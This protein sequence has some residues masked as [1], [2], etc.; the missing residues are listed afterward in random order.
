MKNVAIIGSGIIGVTAAIELNRLGYE[1]TVFDREPAGSSTAA[2]YGN[3]GWLCP[4][5]IIPVAT[6][7]LFRN[8]PS[9]VFGKSAPLSG[10]LGFALRNIGH[11]IRFLN[12]GRTSAKVGHKAAALAQ[13]LGSSTDLHRALA[14]EAQL[15]HLIRKDGLLYTYRTKA[16]L[17][18]DTKWWN[19]RRD[20]GVR[21]RFV[22]GRE[23]HEMEPAIDQKC[24]G[25]ILVIDGGHCIDP[26]AYVKGLASFAA[27]RGVKFRI[28]EIQRLGLLNDRVTHVLTSSGEV[29]ADNIVVCCGAFSRSFANQAGDHPSLMSERGYHVM[30]QNGPDLRRPVMFNDALMVA[31]PMAA[32]VRFAGQVEIADPSSPPDWRRAEALLRLARTYFPS[33]PASLEGEGVTKWMGNRPAMADELPVIGRAPTKGGLFYAFGH[34]YTGLG[35]APATALVLA[36]AFQGNSPDTARLSPFDPQRL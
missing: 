23:L 32:G 3:G 18:R 5:S 36:N 13:L 20:L 11:F 30:V 8:L 35:A 14:D 7:D 4:A 15:S 24:H 2:S 25:A 21:W 1:V 33:L 28:A 22:D 27:S 16:D 26:S 19:M 10:Q 29:H 9:L 34:G 17:E 31:T 6:P 12:S